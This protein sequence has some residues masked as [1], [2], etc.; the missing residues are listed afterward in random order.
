LRHFP[1]WL[2]AYKN[3]AKNDVV[4]DSYVLWAG[5]STLAGILERKVW[6][7]DGGKIAY[8]N[9]FILLVG[10]PG[11]GKSQGILPAKKLLKGIRSKL[12]AG[13]FK[14]IEGIATQAGTLEVMEKPYVIGPDGKEYVSIYIIGSE[15]SDSA[16]KNHADDFRST[17]CAMYDCEADYQKTLKTKQYN[18]PQPVM[19]LIAGSTFDFLKTIVD[20]NS[21][22]GGLASRFTYVIDERDPPENSS[23]DKEGDHLDVD[24]EKKLIEDL[25][26][27]YNMSGRFR[28]SPEG[29]ELYNAWW[30]RHRQQ[31]KETDSERMKSLLVRCPMLLKKTLML[32]SASERNDC[33]ITAEHVEKAV[34]A[35]DGITKDYA[36]VISSAILGNRASQDALNQMVLQ[37]LKKAGGSM[38]TFGIKQ[39]FVVYGGDSSKYE[40]TINMLSQAQMV[41]LTVDRIILLVDP[42]RYL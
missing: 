36:Q 38:S 27:I 21:V 5:L 24:M 19:N 31:R 16:L 8:P 9:L 32:F 28:V 20:Q 30:K 26:Q 25:M 7:V 14:I 4:P 15:A 22:M 2:S 11:A 13:N 40:S 10:T 1:D 33:V 3:Y 17:A 18:I 41:S 42:D 12:Q 35:V 34:T 37:A 39:K 23:L 29:F 6:I